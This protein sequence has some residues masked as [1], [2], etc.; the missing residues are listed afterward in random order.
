MDQRRRDEL[1][2]AELR[3]EREA[4]ERKIRY[5]TRLDV[6]ELII[7]ILSLQII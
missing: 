3:K 4:K 2:Q 5:K 7:P 6:E 1:Y